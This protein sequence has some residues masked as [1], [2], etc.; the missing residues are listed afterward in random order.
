VSALAPVADGSGELA[1]RLFVP[2]GL[3]PEGAM[4]VDV[5]PSGIGH[6]IDARAASVQLATECSNSAVTGCALEGHERR[7]SAGDYQALERRGSRS[8]IPGRGGRVEL[9]VDGLVTTFGHLT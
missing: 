4:A 3:L 6:R 2:P 8:S 5:D 9:R 7:R 1:L